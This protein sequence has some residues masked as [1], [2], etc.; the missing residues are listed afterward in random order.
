MSRL[1]ARRIEGALNARFGFWR[2][3]WCIGAIILIERGCAL[4]EDGTEERQLLLVS[5]AEETEAEMQTHAQAGVPGQR[6]IHGIG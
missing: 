4:A 2:E 6:S 1:G 5:P 3:S